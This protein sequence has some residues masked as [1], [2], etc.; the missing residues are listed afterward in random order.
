MIDFFT[1][2]DQQKVDIFDELCEYAGISPQAMLVQSPDPY[3]GA[4]T[5]RKMLLRSLFRKM[6]E[7]HEDLEDDW[8]P[9]GNLD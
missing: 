1:E 3:H 2:Q 9:C 6:R 8:M 7:Q 5:L 4:A